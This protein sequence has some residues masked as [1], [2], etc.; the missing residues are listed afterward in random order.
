MYTFTLS[1]IQRYLNE[2]VIMS[3]AQQSLFYRKSEYISL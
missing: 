3:K 1:A 2:E